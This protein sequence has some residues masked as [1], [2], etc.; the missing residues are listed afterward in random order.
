MILAAY[1][2]AA[3]LA[4]PALRLAL[5]RVARW[6]RWRI[7]WWSVLLPGWSAES[8]RRCRTSYRY[9]RAHGTPAE[10][11]GQVGYVTALCDPCWRELAT[12]AARIP[13][14]EV[15]FREW[16]ADGAWRRA[17]DLYAVRAAVAAGL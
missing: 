7:G 11:G 15:V 13:Y 4:V 17:A 1:V 12:P 9:A 2:L 5:D 8:C 16:S 6:R 3:L 10:I 14:Y